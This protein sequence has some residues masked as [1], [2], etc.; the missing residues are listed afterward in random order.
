MSFDA[1]I[2]SGRLTPS[3]T[4]HTRPTLGSELPLATRPLPLE[5]LH[6]L[7]PSSDG[8]TI[9]PIALRGTGIR[10][11]GRN[12]FIEKTAVVQTRD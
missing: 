10:Q 4:R 6:A 12:A 7:C 8:S 1:N 9:E 11:E 2:L 5:K 3:N